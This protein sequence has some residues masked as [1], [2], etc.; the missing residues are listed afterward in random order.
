M[1]YFDF[2][3][4]AIRNIINSVKGFIKTITGVN[5]VTLDNCV[6]DDSLTGL[7]IYGN[8]VQDGTPA[9]DSPV[10]I[11]SVGELVTDE[12]DEHYGKYK[13]PI[14]ARGKNLFDIN[15]SSLL[16]GTIRGTLEKID[17][18]FKCTCTNTYESFRIAIAFP[19]SIFTIGKSYSVSFEG[20]N[21]RQVRVG[22]ASSITDTTNNNVYGSYTIFPF[23][24]MYDVEPST[25]YILMLFYAE[26]YE[27]GDVIQVENIQI[28]EGSDTTDYEAYHEPKTFNIWADEP[29]R[30]S[31][32]YAD[33]VDLK[34]RRIK[35]QIATRLLTGGEPWLLQSTNAYGIANY[36][37]N[38]YKNGISVIG[39]V[40]SDRFMPQSTTIA[41]T[42]TEG[43]YGI[44]N[45]HTY[46]RLNSE[47][48]SN[49][50]A[51][52]S[53]LAANNTTVIYAK[54]EESEEQ[55]TL[56]YLPTFKGTTIYEIDTTVPPSKVETEYYSS[57]SDE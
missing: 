19:K 25:D 1:R 39:N 9:P 35:R 8:S 57:A 29:I 55:I 42:M 7:K 12:S 2:R 53:W 52:K 51:F 3:L 31:R 18:G 11:Q 14:K 49:V 46:I 47:R 17:N 38:D 26:S 13:I 48:A 45:S 5:S 33:V 16:S 27:T 24:F 54:N 30:K 43:I 28:E 6:D 56:P 50:T 36:Y 32:D 23:G 21:I 15:S 22:H 34:S 41:N 37:L 10:E 40:L 20:S 4:R 44:A